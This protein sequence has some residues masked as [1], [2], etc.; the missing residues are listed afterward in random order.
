MDR[1]VVMHGLETSDT[2]S[3]ILEECA[4]VLGPGGRV[5]FIVP[6]RSGIWSRGDGT[7]FGFGRPYSASQIDSLLR[8][9]GFTPERHASALFSPPSEKRF[10]LGLSGALELTARRFAPWFAGGVLMIEASKQVHA[11]KNGGLGERIRRPLRIL[12]GVGAKA[13]VPALKSRD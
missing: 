11:P 8:D 13:P 7:P 1:L 6:N 9:H 3:E 5:I 10:W 2:P 4:R 12:E